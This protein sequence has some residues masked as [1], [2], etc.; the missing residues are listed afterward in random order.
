LR[1]FNPMVTDPGPIR[2]PGPSPVEYSRTLTGLPRPVP[3]Y[4]LCC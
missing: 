2:H 3:G 4:R 1:H